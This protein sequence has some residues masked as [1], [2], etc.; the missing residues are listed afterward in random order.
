MDKKADS[1]PP[2]VL[3]CTDMT[4]IECG[5]IFTQKTVHQSFC[6]EKCKDNSFDWYISMTETYGDGSDTTE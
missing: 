6:S 3:E 5:K 1:V 2:D 4:C